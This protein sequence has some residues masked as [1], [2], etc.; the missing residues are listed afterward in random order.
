MNGLFCYCSSL[1]SLPDISNWKTINIY[2]ISGIF[3]G[4]LSLQNL[5]DISK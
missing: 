5:P 2:E 4:C 1:T 3:Y